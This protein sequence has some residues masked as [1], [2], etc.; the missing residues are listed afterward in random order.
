M[1]LSAYLGCYGNPHIKTPNLDR[2]AEHAALFD[3]CYIGSYPTVPNRWDLSTGNCALAD[4]WAGHLFDAC[5]KLGLFK[6][7]MIIWTTD[8]GHLFGDHDLQGKPGAEFGK[9]YETTTRIPLLVH[10]PDGFGAGEHVS[11]IVQPADILPSILEY[12]GIPIPLHVQGRSFRP[13][14]AGE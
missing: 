4:R 8:H 6:N 10:H 5:E 2:F 13:A 1:V 9:L 14:V 3:Q 12:F 7:T 11:G